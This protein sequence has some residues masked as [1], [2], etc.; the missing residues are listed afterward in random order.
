MRLQLTL[1]VIHR[2]RGSQTSTKT[3]NKI[4]VHG[5]R[6]EERTGKASQQYEKRILDE[7]AQ[8]WKYARGWEEFV[9]RNFNMGTG[10]EY[11]RFVRLRPYVVEYTASGAA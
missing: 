3:P 7:S 4:Y 11:I 5:D 1:A 10:I 8:I 6:I 9:V 2:R